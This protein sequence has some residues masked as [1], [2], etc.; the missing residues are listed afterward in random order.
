[1]TRVGQLR[2]PGLVLALIL[3]VRAVGASP[4]TCPDV[5][6]AAL[7]LHAGR[8][9]SIDQ[10]EAFGAWLGRDV[11]YRVVFCDPTKWEGIAAPWFLG[12]TMTWLESRPARIEVISLPLVPESERGRF[13]AVVAGEYDAHYAAFARAMERRGIAHR[14]IVRLGWEGNGDWYPWSFQRDPG[15]FRAAFRR[16]VATMRAVAPRLRFEWCVS[17]R[18]PRRGGAHWTDGYPGDDVVDLVSMDVYDQ[19][20]PDWTAIVE[21]D[22]GLREFR[23]FALKHGKL[24]AY[25]E[26]GCSFDMKSQGGGDNP[27]FVEAMAAWIAARPG[28]VLYHA[29]WNT[30][31]GG[32]RG[33]LHGRGA[34]RAPAA[35]AAYHRLFRAPGP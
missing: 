12:T 23:A 5:G 15:G 16:V 29:Y 4:T 22:A 2:G 20:A 28:G 1:M 6:E 8:D 17:C 13:A 33:V 30:S 32:P 25:P 18:A 7:G 14:V 26:W 31:A 19:W 10:Y 3:G 11:E 21:G 27:R 34:G 9:D 24:E 35:A